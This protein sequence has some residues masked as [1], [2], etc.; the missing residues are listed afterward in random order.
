MLFY[1]SPE[2]RNAL[3]SRLKKHLC[4]P[5]GFSSRGS[6]VVVYEPEQVFDEGL[7]RERREVYTQS[8]RS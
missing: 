8:E 3:R 5:F 1:V 4:V 7:A 6:Q 2:R